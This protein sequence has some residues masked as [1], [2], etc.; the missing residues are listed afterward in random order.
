MREFPAQPGLDAFNRGSCRRGSG[1]QNANA[2]RHLLPRIV[3]QMRNGL[4]RRAPRTQNADALTRNFSTQHLQR[5]AARTDMHRARGRHRPH[6]T[7]TVAV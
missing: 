4:Q 5:K 6:K 3:S 7:P 1:S 2:T